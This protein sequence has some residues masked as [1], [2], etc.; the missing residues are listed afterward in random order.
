M[1]EKG[2]EAN[3]IHTYRDFDL[4]ISDRSV[5]P[6]TKKE[7][8]KEIPFMNG[9]YDFSAMSGEVTYADATLKYKFDIA[10]WTTTEM[11]GKKNEIEDWFWNVIDAEITDDYSTGYFY[12][13]NAKGIEWQEDFGQGHITL[14]FSV[15]PY[16]YAKS[17]TTL[18]FLHGVSTFKNT[19]SHAVEFELTASEAMTVLLNGINYELEAGNM[20]TKK[21]KLKR[22]ENTIRVFSQNGYVN[23]SYREERFC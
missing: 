18:K 21:L 20:D 9:S 22:G 10:E 15:Y 13:G 6:G 16:K 4:Y 11:E 19:S 1:M 23:L 3:G 7:I 14:T 12:K 8:R 17:K 5:T 2:I